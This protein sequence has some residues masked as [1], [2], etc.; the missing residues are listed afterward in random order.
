MTDDHDKDDELDH[1]DEGDHLCDDA[2]ALEDDEITSDEDL[3]A[4]TGG[5]AE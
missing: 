2:C 3:P 1:E 4:S 5:V